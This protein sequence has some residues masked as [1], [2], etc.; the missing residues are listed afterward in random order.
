MELLSKQQSAYMCEALSSFPSTTSKQ[1]QSF[2]AGLVQI[3]S[4]LLGTEEGD[5]GK[6][7]KGLC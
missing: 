2:L 4:F 1:T 5:Q 6:N 7:G 3:I